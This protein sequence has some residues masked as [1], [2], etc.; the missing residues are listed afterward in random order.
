MDTHAQA[1]RATTPLADLYF[2]FDLGHSTPMTYD[3]NDSSKMH[4]PPSPSVPIYP[5]FSHLFSP[6]S[7][8]KNHTYRHTRL[9]SSYSPFPEPGGC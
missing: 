5:G 9:K 6:P 2:D 1:F 3:N 8:P 7:I 4:A